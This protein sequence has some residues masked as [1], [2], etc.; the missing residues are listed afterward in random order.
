MKRHW[1]RLTRLE[2]R[3]H[4][5]LD[6][7][8]CFDGLEQNGGCPAQSCRM[9]AIATGMRGSPERDRYS[10]HTI[11]EIPAREGVTLMRGRCVIPGLHQIP[12]KTDR[13]VSWLR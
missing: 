11:R 12:L 7:T 2:S 6:F 1:P 4:A 10:L 5:L 3:I 13:V 9:V 8:G